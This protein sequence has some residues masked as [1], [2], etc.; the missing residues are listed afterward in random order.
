MKNGL[1]PNYLSSLILPDTV[2]ETSRYNLRNAADIHSFQTR[3]SLYHNS[4]LPSA[5]SLWNT[6]PSEV[7]NL[8]S[9]YSF[10][11]HLTQNISKY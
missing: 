3:T 1:T 11:T 7:Q 4:F 6:L 10:K 5:L 9:L 8:E 2:G